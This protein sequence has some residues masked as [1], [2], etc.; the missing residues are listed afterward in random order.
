MSDY[1]KRKPN[2]LSNYDYS[3][4]GAYFVTICTRDKKCLFWDTRQT[5]DATEADTIQPCT[6]ASVGADIIRPQ[7]GTKLPASLSP[8]GSIVEQAIDN[9]PSVYSGVSVDKYVIMPN[10]VHILL[11]IE[12]R[13][14]GRMLSAPTLSTIVGSMKRWASRQT[15][16]TLWQKSFHEHIIRNERDYQEIWS[17][18]DEN[19][20]RWT[21]DCFY[22]E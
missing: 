5:S 21:E 7:N 16:A 4:P 19:P 22:I 12:G 11:Q 15:G 18:I 3:T 14:D 9:I 10:H 13:E 17:Y 2:R 1:P 6:S 20:G 8:A